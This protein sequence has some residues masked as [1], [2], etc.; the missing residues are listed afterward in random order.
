MNQKS[1]GKHPCPYHLP[2]QGIAASMK[3]GV[4]QERLGVSFV[5]HSLRKKGILEGVPQK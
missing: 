5:I 2:T 4:S 1:L 3:L